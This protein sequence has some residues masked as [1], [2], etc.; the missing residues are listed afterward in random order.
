VAV[1]QPSPDRTLA[2]WLDSTPD[3]SCTNSTQAHCVDGEHQPTDLAVWGAQR[4]FSQSFHQALLGPSGAHWLDDP[5]D[6]TCKENIQQHA[7]GVLYS[8]RA[9]VSET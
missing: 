3:L 5:P 1:H 4:S 7:A 8:W 6:V 9:A 2:V